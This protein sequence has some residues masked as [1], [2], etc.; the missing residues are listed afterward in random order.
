MAGY[1]RVTLVGNIG[2]DPKMKSTATG[3]AVAELS[4]AVSKR[5]KNQ[6]TGARDLQTQWFDLTAFSVL[7]ENIGK[8]VKKGSK[9][10]VDGELR[11][12]KWEDKKDGSAR[13]SVD[14][15]LN[16]FELLDSK[17]KVDG[18]SDA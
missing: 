4:I 5:V 16:T 13:K 9:A 1:N 2:D 8:L 7:A 18:S 15:V 14:I 11:V 10:L 6:D 17:P 12:N 3:V